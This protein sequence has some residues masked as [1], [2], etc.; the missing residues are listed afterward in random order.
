MESFETYAID[1][2]RVIGLYSNASSNS[3][4]VIHVH[5]HGGD[6]LSNAFVRYLHA[7]LPNQGISFLSFNFRLSHY[8][9]EIYSQHSVEYVGAA[10][11]RYSSVH[12]D[13]DAVISF[14]KARHPTY[15]LQGHSF[16]TNLIA[17]YARST[18]ICSRLIFLSP[19][20]SVGLYQNWQK[21]MAPPIID[22]D[23]DNSDTVVWNAFGISVGGLRY[24]IPISHSGLWALTSSQAFSAWSADSPPIKSDVLVIFGKDD[25]I[26]NFGTTAESRT[27]LDLLPHSAMLSLDGAAHGFQNHE[28]ILATKISDWINGIL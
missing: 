9:S 24:N 19:A 6:C 27:L 17:Q 25:P 2:L 8:V 10:L 15:I 11:N 22:S 16:G 18:A 28:G 23:T 21:S 7:T 14:V 5:G 13:F 4:C 26:S 1:G 20:D 3:T 12:L